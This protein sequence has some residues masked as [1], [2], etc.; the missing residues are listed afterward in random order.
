MQVYLNVK[1]GGTYNYHFALTAFK[2]RVTSANRD[3]SLG[4]SVMHIDVPHQ[5]KLTLSMLIYMQ[6]NLFT[7]VITLVTNISYRLNASNNSL[8]LLTDDN[9]YVSFI[10]NLK[11]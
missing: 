10:D 1:S 5:C 11:H 9:K 2:K 7:S 4:L 8:Q 3:A 6:L